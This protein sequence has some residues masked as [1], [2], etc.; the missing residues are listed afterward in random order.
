MIVGA[1]AAAAVIV[2]AALW[3]ILAAALAILAARRLR[4]AQAVL[5]SARTMRGLLDAAPA[6][7]MLVYPDDRIEIDEQLFRELALD[8]PPQRLADLG[9]E[10]NGFARD[11]LASLAAAL[12]DLRLGGQ[13]VRRQIG[14]AAS[15][16]MVEVRAALAVPPAPEGTILLWLFDI[17][18]TE[19]ERA[20]LSDR[21]SQTELALDALTQLI[22]SAPF[23]MWYRGPD[24]SLGLV[25]AAFVAAVEARDAADVIERGSELID[26]S[27]TIS[28]RSGA[29]R[30]IETGKPYSRMQPATIGQERRMLRLVDVPLPTGAVAGFAIDIQ[31]LEDARIDL[32]R[33]QSS[34]RELADRMTAHRAVRCRPPSVVLQSTVRD[35]G[36]D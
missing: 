20:K 8:K 12:S 27:G 22:E 36:P 21:L 34:Q 29:E 1:D 23:P 35:H 30:A 3:L 32:E 25:N 16:R 9:G 19:I 26:A 11:D 31:D 33:N 4:R 17:S 10:A 28:A 18:D 24:L 5:G 7:P 2:I 15:D 14:L 6:R 13:P